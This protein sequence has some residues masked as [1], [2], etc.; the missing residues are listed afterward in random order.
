MVCAGQKTFLFEMVL[1][2]LYFLLLVDLLSC[3]PQSEQRLV[4]K[5]DVGFTT[6]SSIP[7]GAP[8]LVTWG[9]I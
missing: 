8:L 7:D 2:E 4:G 3:V 6:M 1:G 9:P 5:D